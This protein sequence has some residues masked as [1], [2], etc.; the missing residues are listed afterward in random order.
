MKTNKGLRWIKL[1]TTETV[2]GTTTAELDPDERGTW[3]LLLCMAG[4]S[5]IHGNICISKGVCYTPDQIAKILKIP[6]ELYLR[7]ETK[8]LE[9]KKISKNGDGTIYI[10]NWKKYQAFDK[11]EYDREYMETIRR[12]K[13]ATNNT[14]FDTTFDTTKRKEERGKRKAANR[15]GMAAF[16]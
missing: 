12:E 4:F 6:V 13:R 8:L 2:Y 9:H 15:R 11:Q 1:W 16:S 3:F 14:T 10:N 5:M 7:T